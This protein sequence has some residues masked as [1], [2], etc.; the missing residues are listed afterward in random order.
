M[1]TAKTTSS[2]IQLKQHKSKCLSVFLQTINVW[3]WKGVMDVGIW[4]KKLSLCKDLQEWW[5]FS[6]APC[7]RDCHCTADNSIVNWQQSCW[8]S[9]TVVFK[10]TYT[11]SV[12]NAS[13]VFP[14][15]TSLE[16]TRCVSW[17][18]LTGDDADTS[19]LCVCLLHARINDVNLLL[20]FMG[21]ITLLNQMADR[22]YCIP[23]TLT[24]PPDNVSARVV[25][26]VT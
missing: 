1:C 25:I 5:C 15:T 22:N 23:S 13:T 16:V 11:D 24:F 21:E 17:S 14:S 10:L 2:N 6:P 12:N 4:C 26:D 7:N 9:C 18:M 8:S 20:P 19:H 3:A